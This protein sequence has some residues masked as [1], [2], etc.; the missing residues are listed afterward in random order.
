MDFLRK[1]MV[2]LTESKRSQAGQTMTEYVLIIAHRG[3]RIHRVPGAGDWNQRR[4]HEGHRFSE[5]GLSVPRAK[6]AAR[7]SWLPDI[8]NVNA[9]D[10]LTG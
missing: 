8:K 4:H 2:R 1:M 7:P 3:S 5:R 9:A 10:Y 6:S